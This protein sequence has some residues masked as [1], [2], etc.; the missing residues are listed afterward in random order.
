MAMQLLRIG[1]AALDRLL[2]SGINALTSRRQPP[3]LDPLFG[4]LPAVTHHHFDPRRALCASGSNRATGAL[5]AIAAV[6]AVTL[7]VSRA[8]G[9]C[10]I[11][12]ADISV[13]LRIVLIFVFLK[14]TRSL[15]GTTVPHDA[16]NQA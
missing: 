6:F 13:R 10:L 4:L 2:A 5:G 16:G 3:G 15:G 12:R 7:S 8:I 9:Q 14:I 11:V 1:K